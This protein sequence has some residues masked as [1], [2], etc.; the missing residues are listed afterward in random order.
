LNDYAD[1]EADQDN[2]TRN[3]FSGGSRVLVENKITPQN[4]M[5]AGT[6]CAS[7]MVLLGGY[8]TAIY[9]RPWSL[10]FVVIAIALLFAYSFEPF[11]MNYRGGG[12]LLQGIGC[13]FVLP[14][15]GYYLQTG[16]L[17]EFPFL[18]STVFIIF[19]ALSSIATSLPDT[20]SDFKAGKSTLA[21]TVGVRKTAYL[22]TIIGLLTQ[23]LATLFVYSSA[24]SSGEYISLFTVVSPFVLFTG[25]LAVVRFI[26]SS[27]FA[28]LV[29][30]FCIVSVGLSFALGYC[31]EAVV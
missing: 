20:K 17:S 23:L 14:Y 26:E 21:V 8:A 6:I 18:L 11:K 13:G 3:I 29:Y 22:A 16:I 27:R 25:A 28:L 31:I 15:F 7:S 10:I 19:H 1:K 12:E 5:M 30:D 9:D 2:T 4:L 24:V